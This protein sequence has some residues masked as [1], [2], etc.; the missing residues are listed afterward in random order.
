MS[1]DEEQ[2]AKEAA[3]KNISPRIVKVQLSAFTTEHARQALI[4]D[5]EHDFGWQ[6]AAPDDLIR[7]VGGSLRSYWI[8][9]VKEGVLVIGRRAPTQS[10]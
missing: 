3:L 7:R 10:W 5:E 9:W 6:G 1:T 4:H 8:A 2:A